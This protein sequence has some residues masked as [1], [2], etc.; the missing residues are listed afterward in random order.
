V[1]RSFLYSILAASMMVPL[2]ARSEVPSVSLP[3]TTPVRSGIVGVRLAIDRPIY[4][5]GDTIRVRVTLVNRSSQPLDTSFS[6]PWALTKINVFDAKGRLLEATQPSAWC[7]GCIA[8]NIALQLPPRKP[9]VVEYYDRDKH[10]A[11]EDWADL[12]EWGYDL[13]RP[14]QYTL[15]A[16]PSFSAWGHDLVK[17][18]TASTDKSN[19]L[20]VTILP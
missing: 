7:G 11:L 16:S 19:K 2:S 4:H 1:A 17:F 3:A 18:R 10:W 13:N 12:R 14:G 9:V 20:R 5:V 15:A 6:P 8:R